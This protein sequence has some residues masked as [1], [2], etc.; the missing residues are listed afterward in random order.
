MTKILI[1]NSSRQPSKTLKE[2]F[3]SLEE[4]KYH[5]HLLSSNPDFLKDFSR[6][7]TTKQKVYLG[8]KINEKENIF[9]FLFLFPFLCLWR[10]FSLL[11]LKIKSDLKTI[12]CFSWNE[13]IIFTP[14]AKLLKLKIIWI[15]KPGISYKNNSKLAIKLLKSLQKGVKIIVFTKGTGEKLESEIFPKAEIKNI[16]LGIKTDFYEYQENIFSNLARAIDLS[17]QGKCFTV[18]AIIDLDKIHQMENV[19]RSLKICLNG[20]SN[21]RLVVIGEGKEKKQLSWLA[22]QTGVEQYVYLVG[23]QSYLG[24]WWESFDVYLVASLKPK[25]TDF[26]TVL[27]A[28]YARLP[29]ITFE[30][31]GV[32]DIVINEQNGFLIP[33]N[34]YEVLAEKII[35]LQQ[36]PELKKFLGENGHNLVKK[37]FT[38]Q[39]Q[40]TRLE[41][42][43]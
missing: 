4:K 9:I 1:I 34:D 32:E 26:N 11:F 19:F 12:I 20:F 35:Q 25:L 2:L 27:K 38:F 24:R 16:S 31:E 6:E 43:L 21:L 22:R 18:G 39:E 5:L 42:E 14:L 29:V 15:E 36:K 33:K 3:Q 10:F 23:S 40:L 8:P 17:A 28:M 37:H 41:N 7:N 13:R 30:G